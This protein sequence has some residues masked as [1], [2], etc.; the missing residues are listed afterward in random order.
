MKKHYIIPFFLLFLLTSC[1]TQIEESTAAVPETTS[2]VLCVFPDDMIDYASEAE[3]F[4]SDFCKWLQDEGFTPYVLE[5]DK[6]RFE[7][8]EISSDANFYKYVFLDKATNRNVVCN[9][10]FFTNSD[11]T[12]D[13]FFTNKSDHEKAEDVITTFVK[14]GKTYDVYA[15]KSYYAAGSKFS[16]L[17]L[18]F[19]NSSFYVSAEASTSEEAINYLQCFDLVPLE[20]S[21]FLETEVS[22]LTEAPTMEPS[23]T[24]I[25]SETTADETE[26][27]METTTPAV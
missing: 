8:W 4:S 5:Y 20:G 10:D 9:I 6:E 12:V 26:T 21:T 19:E 1:G 17:Y 25:A 7:F 22:E 27:T 11:V 3:F 2:N 15:S 24:E 16:A 23:E 14:D 13:Y 18:P